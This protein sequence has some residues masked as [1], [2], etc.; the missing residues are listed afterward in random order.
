MYKLDHEN[1]FEER[2]SLL[3]GTIS[4]GASGL[5]LSSGFMD[6]FGEQLAFFFPL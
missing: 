5:A 2:R 3:C 6:R 1:L 4:W